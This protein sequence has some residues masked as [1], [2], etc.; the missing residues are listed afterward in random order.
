MMPN[1]FLIKKFLKGKNRYIFTFENILSIL[2]I[3]IGV[4][5]IIVVSSVMNGFDNDI[6]NRILDSKP[7]III[8][9]KNFSPIKDYHGITKKISRIKSI[10]TFA[11]VSEAELV[12]LKDNNFNP[13]KCLATDSKKFENIL[14]IKKYIIIGSIKDFK[15]NS[16]I[17]GLDLSL[18]LHSTVGE[19]ITLS[20]ITGKI[21]TPLGLMPN[22]KKIKIVGI[23]KTGLP[24]LDRQTIFVPLKFFSSFMPNHGIDY[25][26]V[27]SKNKTQKTLKKLKSKLNN[28]YT[29]EDWTMLNGNIFSAIKIEKTV[30]MFVLFLM[31][32]IA[33]FNMS[34]FLIKFIESKNYEIA[35]IQAL[36]I[37]KKQ[38]K[39]IFSQYVFILAAI[40]SLSATL[41]SFVILYLQKN[42][43]F[44][45]IPV[46][47]LPLTYLPVSINPYE[48]IIVSLSA[49]LISYLSFIYPL[50]RLNTISIIEVLR[51]K[52]V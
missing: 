2:G 12:V 5:S 4:F 35:I 18:Q 29:A 24:E 28:D 32:V 21:P 25:I 14:N 34:G 23:F 13:V 1:R 40:G 44:I 45:R 52:D 51:E 22:H 6:T 49:I 38:I 7:E 31:I 48:I 50:K 33:T 17:I 30:M 20:D 15:D 10:K 37:G 19:E 41:I 46:P 11:A 9:K 26:Q 39:N 8:R 16:V 36:G 27:K 47:G 43:H 42:F 3:F